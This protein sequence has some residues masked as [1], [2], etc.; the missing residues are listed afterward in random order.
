MDHPTPDAPESA[1]LAARVWE[2]VRHRPYAYGV[3]I[4]FTVAGGISAPL[5]FPDVSPWAGAIGGLALGFYA[6]L[7][8]VPNKFLE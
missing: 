8:A 1:S 4:G 2:E 7:T 3:L 5:I 6:A